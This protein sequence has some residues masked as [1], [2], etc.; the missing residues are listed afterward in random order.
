MPLVAHE[1]DREWKQASVAES[2]V[3]LRKRDELQFRVIY[4]FGPAVQQ[5]YCGYRVENFRKIEALMGLNAALD[6]VVEV[7]E[8][9]LAQYEKHV[10]VQEAWLNLED[11]WVGFRHD[12]LRKVEILQLV[13]TR[14]VREEVAV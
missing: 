12:D 5:R 14:L 4:C 1:E 10:G 2:D 11:F 9:A 8:V 13:R 6:D 7:E 3:I